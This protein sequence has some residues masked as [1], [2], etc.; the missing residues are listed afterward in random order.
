MAKPEDP[1]YFLTKHVF[2]CLVDEHVILLD[3]R[4]DDYICLDPLKTEIIHTL[5]P[6]WSHTP[7]QTDAV[8]LKWNQAR[9]LSGTNHSTH[10]S[11][12]IMLENGL[13]TNNRSK[14]KMASPLSVTLPP[15]DLTGYN[16]DQKS[17]IR[18][19][20]FYHI[21]KASLKIAARLRFYSLYQIVQKMKG[22]KSKYLRQ[23]K[24]HKSSP[25]PDQVRALVEIFKTLRPLLFSS[26][27]HCLFD[28]FS[29][30]EFLSYYGI[31]PTCVFGISLKPFMAHCWV[32]DEN[33]IYT[34]SLD[35]IARLTP[36]MTI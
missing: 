31:F 17:P 25:N 8:D 36:I 12:Q 1:Q 19:T 18:L 29:L 30:V 33:F 4:R 10:D 7:G 32:Q 2:P 14:G 3:L 16:L 26:K 22:Q 11:L 34:D 5:F 9:T 27:N 28:C 21:L 23:I 6:L 20:H 24:N 35:Y 13:L 15:L